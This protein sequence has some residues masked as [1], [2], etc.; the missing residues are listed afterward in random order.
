MKGQD[1]EADGQQPVDHHL[2]RGIAAQQLSGTA[3]L[4]ADLAPDQVIQ[5]KDHEH[6]TQD[7]GTPGDQFL[8][9][10]LAPRLPGLADQDARI[11]AF[12]LRLPG[13]RRITLPDIAPVIRA[14]VLD[15][16]R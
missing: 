15:H 13:H 9:A 6:A 12:D 11:D 7:D 1:D 2:R 10:I 5:D 8:V 16:T 14:G 3:R 4:D